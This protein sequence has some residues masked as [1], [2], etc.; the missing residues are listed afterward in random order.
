MNVC[1]I[2][3][4]IYLFI[5]CRLSKHPKTT[6]ARNAPPRLVEVLPDGQVG[7]L[8]A[9]A[10]L[11]VAGGLDAGDP[12]EPETDDLFVVYIGFICDL[13]MVKD[14]KLWFM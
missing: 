11:H 6:T 10:Q 14:I 7:A 9:L 4:Y 8:A 13:Y 3:I 5:I 12:E 2:Y 1:Y